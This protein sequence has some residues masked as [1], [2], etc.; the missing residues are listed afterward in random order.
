MP[1]FRV[2]ISETSYTERYKDIEAEN[3]QEAEAIAEDD[4]W[5]NWAEDASARQVSTAIEQV[6]ELD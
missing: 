2:T 6:E 5:R 4:D 3:D 1:K